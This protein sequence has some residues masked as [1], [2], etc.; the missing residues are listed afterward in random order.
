MKNVFER[1]SNRYTDISDA[2]ENWS[3]E[4]SKTEIQRKKEIIK[5]EQSI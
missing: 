5:T 4:A 1:L 2:H 3:K